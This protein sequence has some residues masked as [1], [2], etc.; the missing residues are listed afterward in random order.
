MMKVRKTPSNREISTNFM[1]DVT[2][3]TSITRMVTGYNCEVPG[4]HRTAVWL[5]AMR[6]QTYHWC[7]VHTRLFMMDQ[8]LW[9]EKK[10]NPE[11]ED[12]RGPK[13]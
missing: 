9:E 3:Q 2:V 1:V 13:S 11:L 6:S 8:T 12:Q 5:V 4:C 7:S 10:S